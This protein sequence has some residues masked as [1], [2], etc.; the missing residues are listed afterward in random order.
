[1]SD[2]DTTTNDPT[3]GL[4]ARIKTL[5]DQKRALTGTVSALEARVAELEPMAGR[6]ADLHAQLQASEEARTTAAASWRTERSLL[7]VGLVDE[8]GRLFAETAWRSLPEEGRP[9]IAEWVKS[10]AAPLGV[11][12]YLASPE[13]TNGG[14]TPRPLDH[15][16]APSSPAR[17]QPTG[18][19]IASMSTAQYR[20]WK[21]ARAKG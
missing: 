7:E 3:A 21:E 12:A 9:P 8:T 5:A 17:H 18:Q 10:D 15:G 19:E 11:R 14:G 20:A 2:D 4:T 16:R 13:P 6:L 1:M